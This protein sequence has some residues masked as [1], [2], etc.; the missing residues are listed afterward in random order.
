[1]PPLEKPI[2]Y[3]RW[4]SEMPVR[5]RCATNIRRNST[6]SRGPH[7]AAAARPSFHCVAIRIWIDRHQL[8]SINKRF[9]AG[10]LHHDMPSLP[11]TVEHKD[12]W[13]GTP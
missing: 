2:T 4:G 5:T 8:F 9:K 1:M 7:T 10:G 3:T 6:S 11:R 13:T 12:C